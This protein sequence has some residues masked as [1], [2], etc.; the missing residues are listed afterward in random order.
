[1][2]STSELALEANAYRTAGVDVRAKAALNEFLSRK[3]GVGA[4]SG[5]ASLPPL[6]DPVMAVTVDSVGTKLK[7]A[8]ALNRH[9]DTA[10]DIVHHCTNDILCSGLEPFAFLDYLALPRLD[11]DIVEAVIDGLQQACRNAGSLLLGGET[12]ELP[13][14]YRP[15][16]YE[17]AGMM[18]GIG[19]RRALYDRSTV[20]AGD[21][22]VGLPAVGLHTNGYTLARKLIPENEWR[23]YS[24][25]LGMTYGEALLLE[26]RSYLKQVRALREVVTVRGLAHITGGGLYDNIPRCL[27]EGFGVRLDADRWRLPSL[28]LELRDRGQLSDAE[29][30]RTFNVGIGM[31]AIV[32]ATQADLAIDTVPDA[33]LIGEVHAIEGQERVLIEGR[34]Q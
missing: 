34:L 31:V 3:L 33:S 18:I 26:H 7:V 28:L 29:L 10:R 17:L 16:D 12:P 27:P 24:Q 8:A 15:G 13:E 5:V 30:A 6:R 9:A 22:V 20:R 4:F 32:P 2:R 11:H 14:V 19:E 23:Q 25:R 21:A 1:M